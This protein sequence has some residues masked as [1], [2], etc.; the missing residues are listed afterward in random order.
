VDPSYKETT[1]NSSSDPDRGNEGASAGHGEASVGISSSA[2]S[3]GSSTPS[4]NTESHT[5]EDTWINP[6]WLQLAENAKEALRK[7]AVDAG[8]PTPVKG[9]SK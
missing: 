7:A 4:T 8:I 1:G 3:T 6:G 9:V 5:S 2:S